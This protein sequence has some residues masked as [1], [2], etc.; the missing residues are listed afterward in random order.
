MV[1]VSLN[2]SRLDLWPIDIWSILVNIPC[3]LEN[4]VYSA[5]LGHNVYNFQLDQGG[6]LCFSDL[7][8]L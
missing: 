8:C 2:L 3:V 5:V 1:S 4:P 7:L 6:Q